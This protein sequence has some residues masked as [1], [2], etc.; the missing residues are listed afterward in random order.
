M[1]GIHWSSF[2]M[3]YTKAFYFGFFGRNPDKTL[4]QQLPKPTIF[5]DVFEKFKM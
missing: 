2:G 3:K 4:L 1:G 5:Q